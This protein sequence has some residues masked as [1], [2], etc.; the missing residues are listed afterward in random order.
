MGSSKSLHKRFGKYYNITFLIKEVI[1]GSSKIYNALLKNSYSNFRLEILEYCE[2]NKLL[3]REQYYIDLLQPEYNICKKAGSKL[4]YKHSLIT[5]NLISNTL[6]NRLINI[7]PIKVVNI[8]TKIITYF[9]TNLEAAN[10]LGTSLR[11]LGR[12]KN[13]RKLLY[14]KYCILN[15]IYLHGSYK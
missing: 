10:F 5:K 4:G 7:K 14:N 12:Y 2:P 8:E 1:R 13:G 9:A 3:K 15:N 6:K 11:T